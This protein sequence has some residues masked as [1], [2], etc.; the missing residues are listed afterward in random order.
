MTAI[1]FPVASKEN[2]RESPI[3]ILT[4][5]P[6]SSDGYEK[7]DMPPTRRHE[8]DDF[9]I[10]ES[11]F[12]E[13]MNVLML[14]QTSMCK[15]IEAQAVRE[16]TKSENGNGSSKRL[17]WMMA[18]LATVTLMGSGANFLTSSGMMLGGKQQEISQAQ[19][20][21][22]RLQAEKDK[23]E[24]RYDARLEKQDTRIREYEVWMQTTREKLS[25]K[26]WKMPPIPKGE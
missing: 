20:D 24:Q 6:Q 13:S 17:T 4:P 18:V 19:K 22:Q 9:T 10:R 11:T 5:L 21:L 23:M 12:R 15:V 26:G 14:A 8:D 25:D 2:P 3:K 16:A 7:E 1:T